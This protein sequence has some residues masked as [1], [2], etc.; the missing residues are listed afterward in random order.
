MPM[1][2]KKKVLHQTMPVLLETDQTFQ[3][4]DPNAGGAP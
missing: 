1:Q 4:Y 2:V 3:E